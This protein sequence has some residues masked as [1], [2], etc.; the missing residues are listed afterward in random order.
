MRKTLLALLVG[1][2]LTACSSTPAPPTTDPETGEPVNKT[3]WQLEDDSELSVSVEPWPPGAGKVN[4]VAD[5]S[6]GDW[7]G[8]R[9]IV[10]ALECRIV[11]RE[12]SSAPWIKMERKEHRVEEA[13]EY[14]FTAKDVAIPSKTTVWIQFK[15]SGP[16]MK[17]T[18]PLSDWSLKVP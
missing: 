10:E 12:D 9:P 5:A 11:D 6:L 13:T 17:S 14:Q 16:G 18:N 8:E 7:G 3:F 2:W 15:P 1:L 4:V